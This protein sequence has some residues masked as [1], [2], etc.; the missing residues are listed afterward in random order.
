[1]KKSIFILFVLL[2]MLQSCEFY[3]TDPYY[4]ARD[5]VTGVY[6]VDEYSQTFNGFIQYDIRILKS[7][8]RDRVL[9]ENFYD[10][11][12]TVNAQVLNDKIIIPRQKRDGFELEGNGT[13]WGNRIDFT[14]SVRDTYKR[15]KPTDFCEAAAWRY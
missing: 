9:I 3:Y 14:F 15:S 11:V 7:S 6:K 4:D 13:V 10:A 12:I 1:M 5:R 8:N 2:A